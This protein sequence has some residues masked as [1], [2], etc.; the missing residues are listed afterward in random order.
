[1]LGKALLN[2]YVSVLHLE[3]VPSNDKTILSADRTLL[4]F[5]TILDVN[6]K[7]QDKTLISTEQHVHNIISEK[8]TFLHDTLTRYEV[9]WSV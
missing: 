7:L 6:L 2:I 3:T 1:M 4:L 5:G 8:A 9:Y